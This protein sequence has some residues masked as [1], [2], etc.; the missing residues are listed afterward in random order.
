M[1]FC[2][3]Y[4]RIGDCYYKLHEYNKAIDFLQKALK[5]EPDF[6]KAKE[7]LEECKKQLR[8]K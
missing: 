4:Y 7:L 6:K 2:W 1:S 5:N 3:V 8:K